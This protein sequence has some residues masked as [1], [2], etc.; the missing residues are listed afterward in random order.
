MAIDVGTIPADHPARH[1]PDETLI[2]QD[3]PAN[4]T[5]T[6]DHIETW[7]D[8]GSTEDVDFAAF[9]DEGSDI[10][11]TNGVAQG[12]TVTGGS[13]ESF[14]APG[15]F[16]AFNIA[17]GEYIGVYVGSAGKIEVN[18]GG[19][20]GGYGVAGDHITC[21]SVEFDSLGA[22]ILS[23]YATGTEGNGEEP[24]MPIFDYYYNQ[25]RL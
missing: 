2:N 10:Y 20:S 13:A 7:F 15:D 14:D 8:V 25:S 11:S 6:I 17:L 5:G 3:N 22:Y 1:G 18:T 21:E 24:T 23:L 19:G 4:A 16:T 12:L 9:T